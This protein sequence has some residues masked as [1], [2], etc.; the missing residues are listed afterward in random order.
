MSN[1]WEANLQILANAGSGKT[2]TLVTRIIRLLMLGVHPRRIIALT[3]TRKAAGEFLSKLLQ[4][5][6]SA[7][8]DPDLA[9]ALSRVI[10]LDRGC[11]EY[12]QLLRKV[13]Q[14]L[15]KLQ[16]TTLD[17]FF[18]RIVAAFPQELGLSGIPKLLDSHAEELASRE[19]LRHALE[20]LTS[21]E[22]NLLLQALLERDEGS[23][24][25]SASRDLHS[26]RKEVHESFLDHPEKEAWGDP[27]R[28]WGVTTN[29]WRALA[30]AD[31]QSCRDTVASATGSP[32]FSNK[33]QNAW[34]Q[35]QGL[36]RGTKTN[37][38]V[39]RIIESLDQWKAGT[40]SFLYLKVSYAVSPEGQQAA[41]ALVENYL[42]E[43]TEYRLREARAVHHLLALYEASYSAEVRGRGMLTFS[44]VTNLLQPDHDFTGIGREQHSETSH[45]RLQ[46]DERLDALFDHWLLDEFQ[47]TSRGQY[48]A[49]ENIL[50]EV[51][52]EAARGGE[53]S[54]FCVGDIKQAIYGWRKGDSRLFDELYDRYKQGGGLKREPLNISW[55]SSEEVLATLNAIFGNLGAS[56][57]TISEGVRQRWQR[58]WATHQ[59]TSEKP[60]LPG[61]FSWIT[62]E[63]KSED[64][65]KL[66]MQ[67]GVVSLLQEM[68]S[69]LKQGMTIAL[70]VRS[71]KEANEWLEILR[72]ADIEA[73]SESNPPVGRDN[74]VAAA[75][76]SALS[77]SVHPGDR[78][79][80]NHLSMKPLCGIFFHAI[81]HDQELEH[82]IHRCSML[83]S[84]GGFSAVTEWLL[85]RLSPLINDEFSKGRAAALRRAALKA[86]VSGLTNMDD[87]LSLLDDYEEQGQSAPHAV[88]V[89]TIH[90]SKGLEYDM[91]VIPLLGRQ[92]AIDSLSNTRI[93]RW[94]NQQGEPFFMKLPAEEIRN[95]PGNEIFSTAATLKKEEMAFEELCVW[96]VAM[97]R[98]R[99][100]LYVYSQEPKKIEPDKCPNFPQLLA[101][102]LE[103]L[104]C[105]QNGGFQD[106][107]LGD[108]LT[109]L[110]DPRKTL[111]DPLWYSKF[112][113][114]PTEPER[115]LLPLSISTP[116]RARALAKSRPSDLGHEIL[117]GA[118]AFLANN[119]TALGS[120]IHALFESIDWLPWTATSTISHEARE[121]MERC[122]HNPVIQELFRKPDDPFTLWRE[123]R[124][125]LLMDG[126]WISGC[127]DRVVIFR[128][129]QGQPVSADLIDFKTDQGGREKLIAN[130]RDQLASY[131]RALSQILNLSEDKVR[132]ILI[133]LRSNDPLVILE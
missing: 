60:A 72:F 4:R 99:Q 94:Q 102:G 108:D 103:R 34:S 98:A 81:D 119:A 49:L 40:G 118:Q 6:A 77:L 56:A 29:P 129:A 37:L 132:I 16:L 64:D 2:H 33:A 107:S 19:S 124:F 24:P 5:L 75:V 26:F 128:D 28:I 27:Q 96:Y 84:L 70:L 93:D 114:K 55:R 53:R 57:P 110:V 8:L 7:A 105:S 109:M 63:G 21:D 122:L 17:S 51:I 133:Q 97:S 22:K 85:E 89:M 87:F 39:S 78:F 126:L 35:L 90:K 91:V 111:G 59:R 74:P 121:L 1:Q 42:Y 80:L 45:L 123:Q 88:Q 92:E 127:F 14:D 15:G 125:D 36:T 68:Q 38:V 41:A 131:R 31:L 32:V 54:F 76:R 66:T 112:K 48:R 69:H 116:S 9:A 130:Y 65:R 23:S 100:A 30:L 104:E 13:V 46:L 61:Y 44:D 25:S 120:E 101:A 3:F 12:Q 73:L 20:K 67:E 10:H 47:D 106:G 11:A 52:S 82:F 62:C 117:R 95:V 50:D 79:A 86:D 43:C 83:L 18:N 113:S 71:G 115:D 58:A